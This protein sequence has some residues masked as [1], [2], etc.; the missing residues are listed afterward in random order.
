MKPRWLDA[1]AGLALGTGL[2]YACGHYYR[3]SLLGELGLSVEQFAKGGDAL[4]LFGFHAGVFGGIEYMFVGVVVM[5][6]L[7][8]AI[9]T[10]AL[11]GAIPWFRVRLRA[12][13][14]QRLRHPARR[15]I[16]RRHIEAMPAFKTIDKF[17][18]AVP[19]VAFLFLAILLALICAE[20]MGRKHGRDVI[21]DFD[22]QARAILRLRNGARLHVG[23]VLVCDETTCAY[24]MRDGVLILRRDQI[25]SASIP[26]RP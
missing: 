14:I 24:L 4:I 19:V 8:V 1:A 2:L 13:R 20:S 5:Y 3:Q 7:I 17:A 9:G 15:R 12:K 18:S 26:R 22:G 10:W 16:R 11:I 6:A 23:R 25:V 21:A